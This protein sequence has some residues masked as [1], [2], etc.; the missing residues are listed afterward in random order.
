MQRN[1]EHVWFIYGH[2]DIL[3]SFTAHFLSFH[4]KRC[5]M[6]CVCA[7]LLIIYYYDILPFVVYYNDIPFICKDNIF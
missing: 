4:G 2:D 1:F 5:I 3:I 7:D 6:L